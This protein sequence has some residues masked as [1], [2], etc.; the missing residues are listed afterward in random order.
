MITISKPIISIVRN[1]QGH[2]SIFAHIISTINNPTMAVSRTSATRSSTASN[3]SSIQSKIQHTIDYAN[4]PPVYKIP[5]WELN[6]QFGIVKKKHNESVA[7]KDA[8]KHQRKSQQAD[9]TL[10]FAIRAAG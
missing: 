8:V 6:C 4:M 3:R 9:V 7:L 2:Q 5:L 10:V 1:Q